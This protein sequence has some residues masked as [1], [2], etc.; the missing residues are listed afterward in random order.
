MDLKD[1]ERPNKY[2][3]DVDSWLSL[4]KSFRMCLRRTNVQWPELLVKVEGLKGK[5][6]TAALE[7]E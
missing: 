6:V 5:P 3:G 7:Q 1:V 2:A 4:S